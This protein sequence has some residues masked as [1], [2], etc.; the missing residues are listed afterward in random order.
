MNIQHRS[1]P[2][3]EQSLAEIDH[4]ISAID[5][6][7]RGLQPTTQLEN[8]RKAIVSLV[9]NLATDLCTQVEDLRK[10]LDRIQQQVLTSAERSRATL[11][12]HVHVCERVADEVRHMRE[13]IADLERDTR[14]D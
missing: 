9:D 6:G 5:R 7:S 11:Q 2:E 8:H 3:L 1:T 12:E 4:T 14:D 10:T 13:V